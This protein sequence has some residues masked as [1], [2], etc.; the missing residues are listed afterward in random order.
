MQRFLFAVCQ[1]GM[2]NK[3]IKLG[4]LLALALPACKKEL[5]SPE[6]LTVKL[7][8]CVQRKSGNEA[9]QLCFNTLVQDSR[10]PINASCVWEGV[11]IAR[12]TLLLNGQEHQLELATNNVLPGTRTDTTIQQYHIAVKNVHPYPGEAAGEITYAE[13]DIEKR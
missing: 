2:E 13:V 7:E 11:A 12:F 1:P 10:C 9:L 8:E 6:R 4:I 5:A 3:F